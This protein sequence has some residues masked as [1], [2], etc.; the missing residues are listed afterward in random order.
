MFEVHQLYSW[1]EDAPV[2]QQ[3]IEN[4]L[5]QF[6]KVQ[7]QMEDQIEQLQKEAQPLR[8]HLRGAALIVLQIETQIEDKIEQL[9]KDTQALRELLS[10]AAQSQPVAKK[11]PKV[12]APRQPV[13]KMMPE[14][15][16]PSEPVMEHSHGPLPKK[17]KA[18]AQ[19]ANVT[20]YVIVKNKP[21]SPAAS[22]A[23]PSS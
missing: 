8:E 15:S 3:Y 6:V 14:T 13:D 17:S 2:K 22:R 4:S 12:S 19:A 10:S 23:E 18:A 21:A 20:K 5:E 9:Q 16:A 1:L 11:M 7:E